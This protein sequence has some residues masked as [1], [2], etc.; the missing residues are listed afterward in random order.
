MKDLLAP[1]LALPLVLMGC[2]QAE[3]AAVT[4]ETASRDLASVSPALEQ[5]R[6]NLVEGD[7]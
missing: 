6:Q 2:T 1:A 3:N 4:S 5:F 7:P